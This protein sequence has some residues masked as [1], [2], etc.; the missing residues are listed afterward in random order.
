MYGTPSPP[1][2]MPTLPSLIKKEKWNMFSTVRPNDSGSTRNWKYPTRPLALQALTTW[3]I[4]C[5]TSLVVDSSS[6]F[7]FCTSFSLVSSPV[8]LSLLLR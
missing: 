4:M 5:W 7:K 3:F 2:I 6:S 1:M 8:S